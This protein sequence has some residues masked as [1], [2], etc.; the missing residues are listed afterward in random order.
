M[1]YPRSKPSLQDAVQVF[2]YMR[3]SGLKPHLHACTVL[4]NSLV[5]D[6]VVK[7]H[8]GMV[9]VGVSS[10]V[11]I[12]NCLIHACSRSRDVERAEK[13]LNEME[14]KGIS[15]DRVIYTSIAYAYWKAGNM[16]AASNVL[17]EMARKSLMITI[18]LYRC[19]RGAHD[20]SE[21]KVLQI[22]WDHVVYLGLMS[23]NA[24]IK[25]QQMAI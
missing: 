3:V 9:Q 10:N 6:G 1:F 23:R 2:E 4:L 17:V 13:L 12:Y 19:I 22:F 25:I 21:S 5:K 8:K 16:N 20:N 15:A 11:H 7:V 18:K 24:M 14:G